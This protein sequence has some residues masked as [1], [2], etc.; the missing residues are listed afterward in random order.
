M[1]DITDV[2]PA[3]IQ[4]LTN[5]SAKDFRRAYTDAIGPGVD[6]QKSFRVTAG[7]GNVVNVTGGTAYAAAVG[8]PD[9]GLYRIR[10]ESTNTAVTVA[11]NTSGS[12]PRLDQII[13]RVYDTSIDPGAGA[14]KAAIEVVT[15]DNTVAGATLDNRSG[16]RNL[17][18]FLATG[19]RSVLL[20]ADVLSPVSS[21][22][23]AASNIRD[24]R[25]YFE[26]TAIP[27][28]SFTTSPQSGADFAI[29]QPL[30]GL[31]VIPTTL[32]NGYSGGQSAALCYLDRKITATNFYW[33]YRQA[34][35]ATTFTG[36]CAICDASGRPIVSATQAMTGAATTTQVWNPSFSST[37][38]YPGLY[39]LY[40][41]GAPTTAGPAM[42]GMM[43]NM[44]NQSAGG[45]GGT[46]VL[47][48]APRMFLKLT[49]QATPA[50]MPSGGTILGMSDQAN[51]AAVNI[52]PVPLV[53][54][55]G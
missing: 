35:T 19:T 46:G 31:Q 47:A 12:N 51:N 15:G 36:F 55:Y 30:P 54:I 33:N 45:A 3:F 24:R 41:G 29:F 8:T 27:D 4:A 40:W 20:L 7:G 26:G 52:Q 14:N 37:T 2:Q 6:S 53:A 44:N 38:F 22:A 49:G 43:I 13:L 5:Y 9:G 1:P 10:T 16:A 34:G 32:D 50:A 42:Q 21:G 17:S 11:A 23:I 39:Y 48:P 28:A 18:T 25:Q